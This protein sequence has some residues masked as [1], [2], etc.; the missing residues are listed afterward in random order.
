MNF[1]KPL[2]AKRCASTGAY[3]GPTKISLPRRPLRKIRVGHARPAIYHQFD[4]MVEL[5]DGSVIRRKSQF[6]KEELRLIQDQR[7]NPLWNQSRS[8][9]IVVDANA[10]G[11]MD[12]FKQRYSSIFT[13]EDESGKKATEEQEKD[14]EKS[15][16]DKKAANKSIT[17]RTEV[18]VE[19]D[20]VTDFAVDDYLSILDDSSTQVKTGRLASKKKTKKK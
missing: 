1:L 11:S 20:I 14:V 6:P 16:T 9:L 3:Q 13:A 7:N 15:S 10:G 5:S 18:E 4:V 19:G 8:D 2:I 12:R 17:E